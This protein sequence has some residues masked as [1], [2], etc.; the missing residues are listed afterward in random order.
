MTCKDFH[1]TL[2]PKKKKEPHTHTFI[3]MYVYINTYRQIYTPTYRH[4]KRL[5]EKYLRCYLG[6]YLNRWVCS[7]FPSEL[8]VIFPF[9]YI[10]F[11]YK[12]ILKE[13]VTRELYKILEQNINCRPLAHNFFQCNTHFTNKSYKSITLKWPCLTSAQWTLSTEALGYCW[14]KQASAGGPP[15]GPWAEQTMKWEGHGSLPAASRSAGRPRLPDSGHQEGPGRVIPAGSRAHSPAPAQDSLWAARLR[16]PRE[17][18]WRQFPCRA[19]SHTGLWHIN[20]P[21]GNFMEKS[22][23]LLLPTKC[24][25]PWDTLLTHRHGI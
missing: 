13:K 17:L 2:K 15:D 7:F 1:D 21:S 10:L 9:K 24:K 25:S 5:W 11:S 12:K 22:A 3:Y 18:G 8:P 14:K 19:G 16:H 20:E 23:A 6:L 4:Y